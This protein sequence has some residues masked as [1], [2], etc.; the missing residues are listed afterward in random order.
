VKLKWD[1]R[2]RAGAS[3]LRGLVEQSP[4][5]FIEGFDGLVIWVTYFL[6]DLLVV[7]LASR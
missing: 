1:Q 2:G 6:I 4:T 5:F 3:I 7:A